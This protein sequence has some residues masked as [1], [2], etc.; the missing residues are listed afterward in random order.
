M[1]A[2]LTGKKHKGALNGDRWFCYVCFKFS[3][4]TEFVHN[5]SPGHVDK[6][7]NPIDHQTPLW[8]RNPL[9]PCVYDMAWLD[10]LAEFREELA[11]V[12]EELKVATELLLNPQSPSPPQSPSSPP[13]PPQSPSPPQTPSPAPTEDWGPAEPVDMPLIEPPQFM[14]DVV[15]VANAPMDHERPWGPYIILSIMFST[16][17]ICACILWRK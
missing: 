11:Y 5:T 1:I 14:A 9:I 4:Q 17:S 2:H 13:S 15:P 3:D 8:K 10:V 6:F 12:R 16:V 7:E